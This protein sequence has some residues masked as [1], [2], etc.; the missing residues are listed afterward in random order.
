MLYLG[1]R[2]R[3]Q[4][5]GDTRARI[6]YTQK[7]SW[8]KFNSH[9]YCIKQSRAC[10]CEC[11][12]IHDSCSLLVAFCFLCFFH[13][14]YPKMFR[15]VCFHHSRYALIKNILPS[16]ILFMK[17]HPQNYFH[18]CSITFALLTYCSHP[19]FFFYFTVTHDSLYSCAFFYFFYGE[20]KERS[21]QSGTVR[22][23]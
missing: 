14:K 18:L 19:H 11:L 16:F 10:V 4:T 6:N 21:G 22:K 8:R 17:E 20:F 5:K 2:A 13:Q 3:A 9:A 12:C 23:V 7:K 1:M 15:T